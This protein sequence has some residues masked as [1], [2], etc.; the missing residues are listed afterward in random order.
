[1]SVKAMRRALVLAVSLCA[2]AFAGPVGAQGEEGRG[3]DP[4]QGESLVEVNLPSKDAAIKLQLDAESYGIDFN[5][6]YL[7]DNQDGSV[8]VT[9]FGTDYQLAALDLAG[10]DLGETIEG[11]S[12][13]RAR[14]ATREAE[15]KREDRAKAAALDPLV[16]PQSHTDEIVVLRV[17]YFENY[18]GRFL[19]VEAKDRLGGAMPTGSIYVGPDL[20]VSY[21]KGEGTPIDSP[22]RPM[23]VNIDPDTTPDT[24]VEHRELVRITQPAA[25]TR[26]RIGSSTGESIEA[27][28]DVWRRPATDEREILEGLHDEVPR[29]DR[30]LRTHRRA[31]GRVPEHLGAGSAAEQGRTAT[32]GGRRR[33]WPARRRRASRRRRPRRPGRSCSRHVRGATR[34]ATTSRPSSGIR[35]SHPRR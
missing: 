29:P 28:V 34:A 5:D 15:A 2:V 23:N 10:F 25:P 9:V 14:V 6:H 16:T 35:A 33:R 13:W 20:S 8:T 11:P 22:P 30:G 31:R 4:N 17:D 21:N 26:I 18:A 19:S 7:R 32:S 1:M 24:Y 3:I 12:T 27:D